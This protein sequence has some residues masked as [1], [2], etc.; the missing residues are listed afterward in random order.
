MAWLV[1]INHQTQADKKMLSLM[2]NAA[3]ALTRSPPRT[4]GGVYLLAEI[5]LA[6][7]FAPAR[8]EFPLRAARQLLCGQLLLGDLA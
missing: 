1:L 2:T 8:L 3:S 4:A 7:E 6:A 5:A